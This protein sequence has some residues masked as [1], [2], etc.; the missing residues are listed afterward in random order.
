MKFKVG[1]RV[2]WRDETLLTLKGVPY[3]GTITRVNDP[4]LQSDYQVTWDGKEVA[5]YQMGYNL[6]PLPNGLERILEELK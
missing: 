3:R 6:I 1:D 5:H 4:D 2:R